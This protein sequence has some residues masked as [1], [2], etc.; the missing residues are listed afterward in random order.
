[1]SPVSDLQRSQN[2]H[3]YRDPRTGELLISVTSIVG[4]YSDGDKAGA[5]AGAAVK[6][7]KQGGDYRKEWREKGA[8]GT[9][10]H[11]YVGEWA[12]GKPADVL[13]ADEGHLNA[14][15]AFSN[16]VRPVWL[17]SE[18]AVVSSLGWGGRFDLIGEIE[19]QGER[20]WWCLDVK[21]GRPWELE[22]EMQI[23]GYMGTDGMII[24]DA[25]G[26]AIDLEPLPHV[27]RWGGLYLG[28]DGTATL[29]EVAKP[30]E[31]GSRTRGEVQEAAKQAFRDLVRV[32]QWADGRK[33]Q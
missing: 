1:M 22:L 2:S 8:L 10:L 6:I 27:N 5:F 17:E 12:I 18:R 21:S 19:W 29:L 33:H 9:R 7:T 16:A 14:F 30:P 24:F 3:K 28:A 15:V 32:R 26:M 20:D 13:E 4:S 31:D 11:G 23:A 25:N